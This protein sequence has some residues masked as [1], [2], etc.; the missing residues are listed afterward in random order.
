MS[1]FQGRPNSPRR[2]LGNR[3]LQCECKSC[4]YL[5]VAGDAIY[6]HVTERS[7]CDSLSSSLQDKEAA[8]ILEN[9]LKAKGGKLK[10]SLDDE[11]TSCNGAR[12]S[13]L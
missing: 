13:A 10:L 7:N 3:A 9:L 11:D 6:I 5:I 4:W 2:S 8:V 12:R 1:I